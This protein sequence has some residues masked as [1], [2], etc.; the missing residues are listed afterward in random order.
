[1]KPAQPSCR[2]RTARKSLRLL[3]V[4][5][6]ITALVASDVAVV[7]ESLEGSRTSLVVQN[8]GAAEAGFTYLRTASEVEEFVRLG[9]LVKLP[10]DADYELAGVSF[11]YARAEVR[12]FIERLARQYREECGEPLV[13]TSLTRPITRQP[14]NASELSVHPTGMAV[15][16]RRSDRASCRTWL[17]AVLLRLEGKGVVEATRERWPAHYHISVFGTPYA[18]YLAQ[19]GEEPEVRLAELRGAAAAERPVAV[20]AKSSRLRG[21]SAVH[22][23]YT[24]SARGRSTVKTAKARLAKS[25]LSKSSKAR[26]VRAVHKRYKVGRGDNLWQI[27]RKHKTSVA[28]LKRANK[29]RSNRLKPGQVLSIPAK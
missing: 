9:L 1:M 5:L 7:A 23:K 19:Q 17:E 11:P 18:R 26:A 13:V 8:L 20:K 16:L 12:L 27:A 28:S 22:A 3:S 2:R 14:R 6:P 25:R 4:L 21:R 15:D 29:M 24:R 10:G